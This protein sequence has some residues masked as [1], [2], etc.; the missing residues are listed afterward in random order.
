MTTRA[1]TIK[2]TANVSKYLKSLRLTLWEL[3]MMQRQPHYWSRDVF[4]IDP[5]VVTLRRRPQMIRQ[6]LTRRDGY[7]SFH[8]QA[9]WVMVSYYP[10]HKR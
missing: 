7:R 10:E 3:R 2:L 9:A 5:I 8:F 1:P 4:W 6:W